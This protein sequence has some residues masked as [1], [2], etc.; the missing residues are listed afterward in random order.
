MSNEAESATK[1]GYLRQHRRFPRTILNRPFDPCRAARHPACWSLLLT[2]VLLA[3]GG[4]A[5]N[6]DTRLRWWKGNLHT[7]SLWSDGDD[8]PEMIVD[9]YKQH[10]YQ[11]LA[12]S[13]HNILL[14]GDKWIEATNNRG[15]AVALEKYLKRFG[16]GWVQRRAVKS[17]EQVRL[18]T[19]SEF[20]PLFEEPGRFL[21]IR[22]E[23]ITDKY[24]STPVH[25]NATN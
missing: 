21:L 22:S 13:D 24:K 3:A 8:Y 6:S 9:W 25:L 23:E 14:Q 2:F 5:Q 16:A 15:G 7:H 1:V 17:Q 18:R 11:F 19:L 20:R 10:G 12:L 4:R